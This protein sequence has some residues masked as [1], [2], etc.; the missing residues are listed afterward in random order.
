MGTGTAA[1]PGASDK[2]QPGAQ[3]ATPVT[4]QWQNIPPHLQL[5]PV[6]I[7][8][9]MQHAMM[10]QHQQAQPQYQ[11]PSISIATTATNA[12]P[13]QGGQP[14]HQPGVN[15]PASRQWN[16]P[17]QQ[18]NG[19]YP[20]VPQQ[21]AAATSTYPP[22]PVG[23]PHAPGSFYNIPMPMLPQSAAATGSQV[24]QG[25]YYNSEANVQPPH[26][27][28][29]K[30]MNRR[31]GSPHTTGRGGG[32]FNYKRHQGAASTGNA[33][34]NANTNIH[35]NTHT[36]PRHWQRPP[37]PTSA[38]PAQLTMASSHWANN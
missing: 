4:N 19:V 10:M 32:R 24:R 8:L 5:Y 1:A 16:P 28:H 3:S 26:Q 23:Y 33:N 9:P 35:T 20:T 38:L 27:P 11:Q 22:L 34:A 6:P 36:E 18:T 37:P 25:N 14:A 2:N 21:S 29:N 7:P 30:G 12:A 17:A 13:G 31:G 15:N